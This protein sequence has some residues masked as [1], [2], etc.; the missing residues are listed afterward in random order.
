V[1]RHLELMTARPRGTDR[2]ALLSGGAGVSDQDLMERVRGGE[3]AAFDVLVNRY[4]RRIIA[5]LIGIVGERDEALDGAQE[6]FVRVFTRAHHYDPTSPFKAWLYRIATNVGID[7]VRKRRRRRWVGLGETLFKVGPSTRA[8]ASDSAAPAALSDEPPAPA[9]DA[10]S[11]VIEAERGRMV[12]SAIATLPEKYRTAVVLRDL[13][14]LSYEEIAGVLEC[15]LGT[16]KSRVNR[17]R[18]LLREKL[19]AHVGPGR[20]SSPAGEFQ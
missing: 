5:Y 12:R 2:P 20:V 10:E 3:S 11:A 7:L 15:S 9:G 8:A 4:E 14:E 18:N 16:V 19:A 13:Q 17:A 6:V 1:T